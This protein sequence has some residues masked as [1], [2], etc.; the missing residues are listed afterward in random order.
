MSR[1]MIERQVIV[2]WHTPEEK[3]PPEYMTVVATISGKTKRT[4][5]DVFITYDHALAVMEWADDGCGWIKVDG[6]ELEELIVHAWC[7]LDAYGTRDG[8][9]VE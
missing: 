1:N 4:D 6:P 7:D 9:V 8:K 5:H 3:L 2:T